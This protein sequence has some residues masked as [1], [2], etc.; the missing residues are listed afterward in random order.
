MVFRAILDLNGPSDR[1]TSSAG[2]RDRFPIP[3][4]C[5]IEGLTMRTK[6]CGQRPPSTGQMVILYQ[7]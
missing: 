6:G 7:S 1:L 3:M 4:H 5:A 2:P